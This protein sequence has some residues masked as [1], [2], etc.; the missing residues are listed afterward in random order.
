MRDEAVI[1]GLLDR[2]CASIQYR[3]RRDILCQ[4][5]SEPDMRR[6][7]D[8]I[9]QDDAVQTVIGW[10]QPDG[11]LAWSFHGTPGTEMGVRLLCEKGLDAADAVVADAL[12]ALEVHTDRL[13]RGIGKVGAI[14]DERRLGGS[15]MIRAV[16]FA[17]AGV[18]DK[19]FVQ[20]QIADALDAFRALLAVDA[21]GELYDE[22]EGKRAIKPGAL[23]PSTYHLRLLAWTRGW[24]TPENR[25]M[26]IAAVG[27]LIAF[28]P[29]PALHV[30]HGSQWVAPASFCMDDF[31]PNM[32]ALTPAGWMRW[33]HRTELLARLGVVSAIPALQ[34]QVNRLSDMMTLSDGRFMYPLTHPYFR[35]WNAYTGLMLERDWRTIERRLFDLTFR[36]LLILHLAETGGESA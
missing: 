26:L 2:A 6:L 25:A 9:L 14:L 13:H 7:H 23:F 21:L 8:Q 32:A 16:V 11:W 28:S 1:G 30:L 4:P 33:F 36:S 18:E 27:R 31:D 22:H 24:R 35:R 3:L 20:A 29:I 19:P 12:D 15:E 5:V 10:Q 17:Y 34:R